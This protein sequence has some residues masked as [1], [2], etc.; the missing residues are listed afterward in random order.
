MYFS[1]QRQWESYTLQFISVDFL[2]DK[3][4]QSRDWHLYWAHN[5]QGTIEQELMTGEG[6][7][8]LLNQGYSILVD[9]SCCALIVYISV[10]SVRIKVG[11]FA[12][13]IYH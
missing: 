5:S 13:K 11:M 9:L 8:F 10:P 2:Q 6:G 12:Q 1:L 3:T 4:P 7:A